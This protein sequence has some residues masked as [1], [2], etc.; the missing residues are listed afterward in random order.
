[1]TAE[2]G[3]A[4][5]EARGLAK[6]YSGVLAVHEISFAFT[7]VAADL[8]HW[9]LREPWRFLAVCP[10]VAAVYWGIKRWLREN[11]ESDLRLAFEVAAPSAVVTLNLSDG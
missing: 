1:M 4:I 11:R 7:T 5:L 8:E 2:R 9:M 10:A 3:E 6:R